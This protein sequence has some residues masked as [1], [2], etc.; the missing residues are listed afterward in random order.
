MKYISTTEAGKKWN[1]S[2]R[3]VAYLCSSGRIAGAQKAGAYWIILELSEKPIDARIKN[4]KYINSRD[5]TG[6]NVE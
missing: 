4:G 3:R 5:L 2:S 1:L 6:V